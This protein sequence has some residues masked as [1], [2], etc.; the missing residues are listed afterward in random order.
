MEAELNQCVVLFFRRVAEAGRQAGWNAGFVDSKSEAYFKEW[1]TNTASDL[2][3]TAVGGAQS[4]VLAAKRVMAKA[5]GN[6]RSV[7]VSYNCRAFL[8][9]TLRLCR[10]FHL[11]KMSAKL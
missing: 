5:V 8:N 7:L 6:K 1:N 10:C 3:K 9:M 11:I 4:A 2:R